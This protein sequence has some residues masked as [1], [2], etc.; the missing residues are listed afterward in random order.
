MATSREVARDA[1]VTLLE[2]ALVG[3]GL[4]AKTVQGS[5][6]TALEG[7]TPLVTVLS[8]G[9]ERVALTYQGTQATFNYSILI[10]V[11]QTGAGGWTL[12]NAEDA[13][14]DI[15]RRIAGVLESNLRTAEWS[16]ID[17]SGPTRVADVA[18]AGVPYYVESIPI[19][20]MLARS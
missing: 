13:L 16:E 2:A 7:I 15:E 6:A 20:V 11:L 10:W 1:L 8:A 3:G 19:R 4:P 17:Y 5:K 9:T 18:V 12:A 14:D